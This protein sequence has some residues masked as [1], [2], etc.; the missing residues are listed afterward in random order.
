MFMHGYGNY[1]KNAFPHDELMPLSCKGRQRG[2]SPSRG[3]KNKTIEIQFK[4]LN[5]KRCGRFIGQFLFDF[6]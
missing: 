1:M 3:G 5:K 4:I 2:V 6:G